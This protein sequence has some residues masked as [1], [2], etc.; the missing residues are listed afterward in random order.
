MWGFC[1]VN[2]CCCFGR[3]VLM[4]W[5]LKRRRWRGIL[6]D[7]SLRTLHTQ[8][9]ASQQTVDN[10][11]ASHSITIITR[12]STHVMICDY[13]FKKSFFWVP[14]SFFPEATSFIVVSYYL[15][16]RIIIVFSFYARSTQSIRGCFQCVEYMSDHRSSRQSGP[17]ERLTLFV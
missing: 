8:V 3:W 1:V 7:G 9:A 14:Q 12:H 10:L 16:I 13:V 17:V 6:K 5:H 2:G 15:G 11:I 4:L